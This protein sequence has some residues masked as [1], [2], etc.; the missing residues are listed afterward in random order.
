VT[1][2][3]VTPGMASAKLRLALFIPARSVH[4]HRVT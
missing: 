2:A 4:V 1:I 3:S